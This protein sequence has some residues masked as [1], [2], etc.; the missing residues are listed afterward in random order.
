MFADAPATLALLILTIAVS[1]VAFGSRQVFDRFAL[2]PYGMARRGTWYQAITSGFLHGDLGH[3]AFNMLTLFF[4]GPFVE[5]VLGAAGF[6]IVYFGAMLAGSLLAFVRRKNEPRYRAIGA[7][8]A[9]SG[10]LF[11]FVLM[12]PLS[13]IYLFLLPIGIPAVLFAV[14]YVLVSVL[15]MKHRQ[16]RIGHEAHLGGGLAGMV[17]T[18][19]LDPGFLPRFIEQIGDAFR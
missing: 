8:G 10:V 1:F 18:W 14:G 2:H 3:L 7:S 9:I 6:L 17:L 16:G 4:F 11:G 19:A 13:P 15:G 5:G 12:R